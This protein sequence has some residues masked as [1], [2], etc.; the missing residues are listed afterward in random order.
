MASVEREPNALYYTVVVNVTSTTENNEEVPCSHLAH[1]EQSASD[2]EVASANSTPQGGR[3]HES[4]D[5]DGSDDTQGS[6]TD[7]STDTR[8]VIGSPWILE[9]TTHSNTALV[10]VTLIAVLLHVG[11][12]PQ[13]SIFG[14]RINFMLVLAILYAFSG[15]ARS[16]VIAGF[17]CGLFYDLTASVP[18]GLMTL[19][20]YHWLDLWLSNTPSAN[21]GS[22]LADASVYRLCMPLLS[23]RYITLAPLSWAF[24]AM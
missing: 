16:A 14:G 2:E 13:I 20:A 12:G 5:A 9:N 23:H 24:E 19:L 3:A 7:G 11:I 21:V 6:D 8:S 10:V 18:V 4:G 22:S 17:A 1:E 15:N